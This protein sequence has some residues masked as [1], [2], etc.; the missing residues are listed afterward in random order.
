MSS[1]LSGSIPRKKI[2]LEFTFNNHL[3]FEYEY[4]DYLQA[5]LGPSFGRIN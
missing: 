4:Q 5:S 2:V 1:K 3:L